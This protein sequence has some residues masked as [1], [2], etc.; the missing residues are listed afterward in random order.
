MFRARLVLSMFVAVL[1]FAALNSAS[2]S[3]TTPGWMLNGTMLSAEGGSAPL[4]TEAIVDEKFELSTTETNV[5]CTK[6]LLDDGLIK[7]TNDILIGNILFSGCATGT[8]NCKVPEAIGTVPILIEATLDT[9][10]NVK[11]IAKPESGTTFATIKFSGEACAISGT[12]GATGDAEVLG[13]EGQIEKTD[14]LILG[15]QAATG[16]LKFASNA[17]S[18]KGAALLLLANSK[19]WSFL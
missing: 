1:G 3:A 5:S 6:A 4:A 7:E 12:K 13:D 8:V 15:V 2:A 14:Q 18:F 17:A 16:L 19:G 9:G 11:G 10:T